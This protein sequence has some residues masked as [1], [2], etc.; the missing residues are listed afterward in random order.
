MRGTV[1]AVLDQLQPGN[2]NFTVKV[3]VPNADGA[4][5]AGMPVTGT[6]ALPAVSGVI[7]PVS[8]FVDD[9]RA[10]VYVVT[11]GVATSQ[12]VNEVKDDGTNAVVTGLAAGTVVVKDVDAANVGNG[13]HVTTRK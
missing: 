13:D 1:T 11:N 4:L 6:V 3:L 2:T 10:A 5:H 12:N 8:A 7:V 9:T